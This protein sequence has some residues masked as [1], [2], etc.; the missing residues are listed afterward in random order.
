MKSSINF[1]TAKSNSTNHM[2]R[3]SYTSYLI[4]HDENHHEYI[5]YLDKDEYLGIAQMQTKIMTKRSMQKLAIDN[6]VQE[7]VLNIK[8]ETT[9]SDIE[10]LF[11]KFNKHFNGGFKV[12]EIAKHLDE[13]VFIDTKYNVEEITHDS[14]TLKWF[15]KDNNDI[16]NEV[17]SL[18]P[19]RDC[20]YN[21]KDKKW[22]LDK[23]FKT[24]LDTNKLQKWMN[25]HAHISFTK[26]DKD[27]GKNIRLQ[28]KD[29]QKIQDITAE[30]MGME[31]G[32]KNS[33]TVRMNHHQIKELYS[34]NNE[35][36]KE[37]N[38]QTTKK[39]ELKVEK[40]E[41]KATAKDLQVEIK[42]LRK[43]LS[44]NDL[45]KE[46][47]AKVNKLNAELKE[48]IKKDKLSKDELLQELQDLKKELLKQKEATDSQVNQGQV[49]L[50]NARLKNDELEK[51]IELLKNK[52]NANLGMN[53]TINTKLKEK[54]EELENVIKTQDKTISNLEDKVEQS[55]KKIDELTKTKSNYQSKFLAINPKA[56]NP[57][58]VVEYV[59]SLK[60][61]ISTLEAQN[62]VYSTKVTD[63][64][65]EL[66]SRPS[67]ADLRV[68]ESLLEIEKNKNQ[69]LLN[70]KDKSDISN[71]VEKI[72]DEN[73]SNNRGI[74]R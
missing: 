34:K 54:L 8:K 24:E 22:Y 3:E 68:S 45:K 59:D 67:T 26:W 66:I 25:N 19:N 28:K 6:F 38:K 51:E 29:L 11:K 61:Q 41:L 58:E 49:L 21:E 62:E 4:E 15:D 71:M 48:Q 31:R 73:N 42:S 65:E 72:E 40:K 33:K 57:N 13:G 47:F 9:M 55:D 53:N 12:F 36:V 39:V 5:K 56:K 14:K 18:A 52:K 50:S 23:K 37:I 35:S 44:G 10:D 60:L 20:F 46:D 17:I 1:Q 30:H 63:L 2:S 74:V 27:T 69:R 32:Q 16:T 43:D 64:E 7:A 70:E